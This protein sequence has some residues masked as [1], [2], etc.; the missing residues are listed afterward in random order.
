MIFHN[1]ILPRV[2]STV[3]ALD[4]STSCRLLR[5]SLDGNIARVRAVCPPFLET[6]HQNVFDL[7]TTVCLSRNKKTKHQCL[8]TSSL[9]GH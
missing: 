2:Y 9:G 7:L 5:D 1:Y 4:C 3:L 8:R 6:N